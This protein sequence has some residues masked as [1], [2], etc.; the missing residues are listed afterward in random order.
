M[1]FVFYILTNQYF[2]LI[3]VYVDHVT[4]SEK[5]TYNKKLACLVCGQILK[6]RISDHL[7]SCHSN[8]PEVAEALAKTGNPKKNKQLSY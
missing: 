3:S 2:V 6:Y 4:S 7:K 8:I 1:S 5:R